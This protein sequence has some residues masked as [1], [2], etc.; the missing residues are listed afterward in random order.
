VQI[1]AC[2]LLLYR[3]TGDVRFRNAALVANRYA[4]STVRPDGPPETRGALK[5]SFPVS[6]EYAKF[7]Y[8]NWATKFFIDANRLEKAVH[9]EESGT[10]VSIRTRAASVTD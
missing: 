8:P 6:G 5:G 10:P 2:W 7:Q 9:E 4:R 3:A 1:A